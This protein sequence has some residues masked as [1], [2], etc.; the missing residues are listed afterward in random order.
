M[1]KKILSAILAGATFALTL[2]LCMMAAPV[3]AATDL[4]SGSTLLTLGDSITA[5]GVW[6]DTVAEDLNMKLVNAGVGGD[7]TEN[8]RDRFEADVAAKNPDFVT[9]GLGTN[10]FVREYAGVSKVSLDR[11]RENLIY[12]IDRIRGMNATPILITPPFIREGAFGPASYYSMDGGLNATLDLYVEAMRTV[13]TDKNVLLVDMHAVTTDNYQVSTFLVS[14]GVHLSALGKQVYAQQL[15]KVLTANFR[16]DASVPAV[17]RPQAPAVQAG[18]W[19]KKIVSFNPDDWRIIKKGSMT[20]T[21]QDG[22]LKIANT[23][24]LWPEA[25]YSPALEDG[26]AIPVSAGVLNVDIVTNNATSLQIYF[27]GSNPTTHYDTNY[28]ILNTL[29]KEIDPSIQLEST[30]NDILAGQ[31]IK[32][33]IPLSKVVPSSCIDKNGNTVFTGA[34]I[35][36]IGAAGK[37]V[38]IRDLSVSR[39]PYEDTAS[40]LPTSTSAVSQNEGTVDFTLNADGTLRLARAASSS[41]AWPS[42]KF[43]PNKTVNLSDTPFLHLSVTPDNGYANGYVYYTVNGKENVFQLS[44]AVNGDN[45][46]FTTATNAYV[47][48]KAVTGQSSGSIVITKITLSV[49]GDV[50]G[51]VVWNAIALAKSGEMSDVTPGDVNGDG[52]VTTTDVRTLLRYTVSPDVAINEAA[53]DVNGDGKITTSDARQILS[54]IV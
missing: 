39:L 28:I 34:K 33:T 25:H 50:G 36:V 38:D 14:D 30:T 45:M 6:N 52:K 15:E 43:S 27:N 29:L 8:A 10:D 16:T 3:S 12:F 31:T 41:I 40:L 7:T 23:T 44:D 48:L 18:S 54:G 32:M 37:T 13:A 51:A 2:P 35:Y 19:T 4:L 46:D 11:Y 24:G 5:M 47:D 9:I 1:L 26:I 17:E 21:T 20:V 53:A 49:Y 42:V 22:V